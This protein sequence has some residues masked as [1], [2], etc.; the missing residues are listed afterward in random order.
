[1][2]LARVPNRVIPAAANACRRDTRAHADFLHV[3]YGRVL[4]RTFRPRN[5]GCDGLFDLFVRDLV[6][7]SGINTRREQIGQGHFGAIS[8]PAQFFWQVGPHRQGEVAGFV[9]LPGRGT[10]PST[11]KER[12]Q[13]SGADPRAPPNRLTWMTIVSDRRIAA[14]G[15]P[16]R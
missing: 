9:G 3:A 7:E 2:R 4:R 15:L 12:A 5:T 8:P 1:M 6:E 10:A 11:R 16:A 13:R 14:S